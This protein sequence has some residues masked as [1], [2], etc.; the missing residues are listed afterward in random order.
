MGGGARWSS[1]DDATLRRM[2]E[3][4]RASASVIAAVLQDKSRNAVI[5]RVHRMKLLQRIPKK[6]AARQK[7]DPTIVI[8][9]GPKPAKKP[10]RVS[11]AAAGGF[12]SMP[13]GNKIVHHDLGIGP[14]DTRWN[15]AQAL[16]QDLAGKPIEDVSPGDCRWPLGS[17]GAVATHLC[18]DPVL[19]EGAVYCAHHHG[20]SYDSAATAAA[21]RKKWLADR[22]R[23]DA[24]GARE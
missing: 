16:T 6:L 14:P 11:A 17:F 8:E 15:R 10:G 24:E 13:I 12:F 5:G 3:V 9:E 20:I 19:R 7:P 1:E 2:W 22:G 18:G 23:Q 21:R 4:E